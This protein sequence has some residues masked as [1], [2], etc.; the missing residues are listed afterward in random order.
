MEEKNQSNVC[1]KVGENIDENS[2]ENEG[3]LG[4][5]K[6]V[7]ALINAYNSLQSEFTKRC[8]RLKELEKEAES[9]KKDSAE[10]REPEDTEKIITPKQREEILRD[11]LKSV[12]DSKQKAVLID[13]AGV[14]VK[15]PVEKPKSIAEAGNLAKKFL[16]D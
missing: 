4:K 8:Q 16:I 7:N 6:D 15:T 5:F 12:S 9:V 14:C 2:A 10:S 1:E 3:I 11:Y 13:G